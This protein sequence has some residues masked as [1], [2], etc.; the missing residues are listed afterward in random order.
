[1]WSDNETSADLLGCQHLVQVV[2][3]IVKSEALL[4][5][6]I[7]VFGDWGSGKSSLLRIVE[8]ELQ[9]TPQDKK[10][11]LVLTFNG[12]TFEGYEDARTSLMSTILDEVTSKATLTEKGRRLAVKLMSRINVMRVLGSGAKAALA[13]GMGGPVGLG[14]AAGASLA[15]DA[16]DLLHKAESVSEDEFKK[17]I[18]DEPAHEARRSIREFRKDFE[19][20]IDDTK[21]KTLVVIID[22]LDRCMPDT[23][24]ETLEAIKL[25]LYAKKTAFILGADERLVQYAVRKRFPEL[26]GQQVEVGR[27]YL[28]KL[29]QFP[30]R[31]LPL[32]QSEIETYINLLFAKIG[33]LNDAQ[34]E[35]ARLRATTGDAGSLMTVRFNYGVAAEI[36]H[37]SQVSPG[38]AE[39]LAMAQR[40]A[41]FLANTSG[42]PRQVKRFL[43][44]VLMRLMMAK[45]RNV[46]LQQRVMTKLMLLEYFRAAS[47]K[48]LAELQTAEQGQP[49]EL[50]QAEASL[51]PVAEPVET[52]EPD[53]DA[54]A[55]VGNG[56]KPKKKAPAA[57]PEAKPFEMP[58]WLSDEWSRDWLASEP[59]LAEVDLRPYFYFSRDTLGQFGVSMPRLSPLAQQLLNELFD[60]SAAQRANALGK[61]K[62]LNADEAVSVFEA[63]MEKARREEDATD[64]RAAFQR[65]CDWAKMRPELAIQFLTFLEGVAPDRL[66]IN[67]IPKLLD[68]PDSPE[69]NR[70]ARAI[71]VSW[72]RQTQNSRLQKI[73]AGRLVEFK[74]T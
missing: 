61:A 2:T 70:A 54:K 68:L 66:P 65:C 43:N 40:I 45:A 24:I 19:D 69:N 58:T 60:R 39:D 37:P 20:L 10:D 17:Y 55:A 22:D 53:P 7:G 15:A 34:F 33:G 1:M 25:F 46:V 27:D 72:S 28:E 41:P 9:R 67:I 29:V 32:G 21:L 14:L 3:S 71:A 36:L 18:K 50:S 26:P 57:K 42:Y 56:E 4:P 38:F 13:F 48:K 62:A 51:R 8:E 35:Q 49:A 52:A 11:V 44:M 74:L 6:T 63:L 64:E 16:K 47:F 73:A 5:A 31:I 12:W 59:L 23:I 30:I